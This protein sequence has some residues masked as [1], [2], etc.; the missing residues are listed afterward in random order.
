M[1]KTIVIVDPRSSGK[2][3]A[4]AFNKMGYDCIAVTFKPLRERFGF[5]T[6]INSSDFKEIIQY[7]EGIE[8]RLARYNPVAVFAGAEK[9]V[10]LA[11]KLSKAL[12]PAYSN[13]HSPIEDRLNKYQ[14]QRAVKNAGLPF[15]KTLEATS[16]DEA[17]KWLSDTELI[18]QS[19]ILKPPVSAGSEKVFHIR[20]GKN[21]K[22]TFNE[23]LDSFSNMTGLKNRSVIIQEE[24][25]GQ[26]FSV[27]TVSAG[28]KH[29][30]GHLIK[31]NKVKYNGRE[32]VYDHVE[33]VDPVDHKELIDFTY[34]VLDSLGLKW[35][36]CHNEVM[37]TKDGPRLI[38]SVP[39]MTGGPVVGFARQATGSSQAD[40]LVEAVRYGDVKSQ[41]Y[42]LN[43]CLVPVFISSPMS[44]TVKN[45]EVF[46]HVSSLETF[47]QNHLWVKNG[48]QVE[49]T[50]DYLT[51]LGI[52]ALSG[53]RESVFRD[54]KKIRSMESQL[55]IEKIRM[56]AK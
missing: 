8:S 23:I 5:A 45:I 22:G 25:I 16:L 54:F 35:G 38:E 55:E 30:L 1:R 28:G 32:T 12:T 56:G 47:F 41:E 3:L 6:E 43:H 36:A 51:T 2:E 13:D 14:M 19:F 27:G 53:D 21:W 4:P 42:T 9:G 31:Y 34:K 37:M 44:G 52:I 11:E 18:D 33:F 40:K 50:V 15:L 29:Y 17:E 48:D 24:A 39:R 7:Q 10:P 20:D 49:Q 26:E 46:D